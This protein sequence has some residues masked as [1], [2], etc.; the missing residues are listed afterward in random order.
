MNNDKR[1]LHATTIQRYYRGFIFRKTRL[2][3]FLYVIKKFLTELICEISHDTDDGRINSY[4]DEQTIIA[5]IQTSFPNRTRVPP[6]RFW[7]D[8]LILDRLY[9]WL[10]VNIKSTTMLTPDNTGNL[11]MCVYGYTD[12]PMDVY[13][14]SN[15]Y[16]NGKMVDIL[17]QKL[18]TRSF[19]TSPKRDYYFLVM[20]K[21]SPT[22]IV[23]NSLRGLRKLTP[24]INNPPFQVKWKHN[25]DYEYKPVEQCVERF[26]EAVQKTNPGWREKFSREIRDISIG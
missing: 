3:L 16:Y 21:K 10:P 15:T 17:K 18:S 26:L 2:P 14:V 25:R 13:N 12:Y 24:N 8:I 1:N 4:T 5:H 11:A 7:F 9:G 6:I 22:D 23:I 19:N 20:N